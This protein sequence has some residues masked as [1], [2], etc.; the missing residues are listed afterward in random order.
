LEKISGVTNI[1]TDPTKRVC[2]FTVPE[3]STDYSAKLAEYAETNIH[4]AGYEIQ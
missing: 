2:S 3:G 4:L 1:K